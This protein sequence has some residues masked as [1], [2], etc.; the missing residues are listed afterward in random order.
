MIMIMNVEDPPEICVGAEPF[1]G[2]GEGVLSLWS[3]A[4]EKTQD[5]LTEEDMV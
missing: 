1:L 5:R 2:E 3:D 4:D